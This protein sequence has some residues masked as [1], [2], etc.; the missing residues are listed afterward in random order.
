MRLKPFN[1]NLT[2]ACLRCAAA[3]I[4]APLSL[5]PPPHAQ[6][7][8]GVRG[9]QANGDPSCA[10]S[11]SPLDT[12]ML[13]G[14]LGDCDGRGCASVGACG[15]RRDRVPVDTLHISLQRA[16]GRMLEP[17]IELIARTGGM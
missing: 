9:V 4:A 1:N 14:L 6:M 5:L 10:T 12:A 15:A 13:K 17:V 11:S 3:P 7:Y 2:M 8:I 16:E